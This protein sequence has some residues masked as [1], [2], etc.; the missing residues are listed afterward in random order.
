MT[1]LHTPPV[2][3]PRK[4]PPYTFRKQRFA[5]PPPAVYLKGRNACT[6]APTPSLV[7]PV[8]AN[9]AGAHGCVSSAAYSCLRLRAP[10]ARHRSR[11][12]SQQCPPRLLTWP[13]ARQAWSAAQRGSCTLLGAGRLRSTKLVV[14]VRRI[15]GVPVRRWR[16][17][18]RS[19]IVATARGHRP[20]PGGSAAPPYIVGRPH[21]RCSARHRAA[22]RRR[23]ARFSLAHAPAALR[24]RAR[25]PRYHTAE[26]P[27]G[28]FA[29]DRRSAF[30]L[31][32]AAGEVRAGAARGGRY[33]ARSPAPTPGSAFELVKQYAAKG[34][35]VIATHRR[36]G[37]PE[38]LAP[39]RRRA[40]ERARR[41]HG[42]REHRSRSERWPPSSR[43]HLIDVL[44]N[45]AGIYSDRGA[46]ADEA[47]RGQDS[48]QSFGNIDYE[49]FDTIMAIN[50]RGP[51]SW[52]RR[53]SATSKRARK[54]ARQHQLDQR[55]HHVHRSAAPARSPTAPARPR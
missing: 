3:R 41:A 50:V 35:T 28:G 37:A 33:G 7:A 12:C 54:E 32:R 5:P 11:R 16:V 38:T 6:V 29:M 42:R 17:A 47:C 27:R 2:P 18:M 4:P 24:R 22:A 21:W 40:Q 23:A 52:P 25:P 51:C 8:P 45:N 49:L 30:A 46:C 53:S 15:G 44:I 39:V 31:V 20:Q 34:W 19:R 36:D 48:T 1:Q 13:R 14:D 10:H 9:P 55:L 26:P 43:A